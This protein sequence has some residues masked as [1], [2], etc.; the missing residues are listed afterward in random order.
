MSFE[1]TYPPIMA[2]IWLASL[3]FALPFIQPYEIARL[4]AIGL[5]FLGAMLMI[6]KSLNEGI[7]LSQSA[8]YDLTFLITAWCFASI[9]WSPAFNISYI[10]FFTFSLLPLSF[11]AFSFC[12]EK[13]AIFDYFFK[14]LI[15]LTTCLSLFAFYQYFLKPELLHGGFVRYPFA[16]PNSFAA[17]L[18]LGFFLGL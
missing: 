16:N 7:N 4:V 12:S 9:F 3:L 1:R 5:A 8:F 13:E 14:G 6:G 18:S 10:S 15:F 17:L 11:F 2:S